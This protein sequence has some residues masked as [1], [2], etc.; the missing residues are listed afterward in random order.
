MKHSFV[1]KSFSK[2][3]GAVSPIEWDKSGKPKK[4]TI[5]TEWGE[6]YI[7]INKNQDSMLKPYLNRV[8][9]AYGHVHKND[10]G[11]KF[12]SLK[13]LNLLGFPGSTP[14]ENQPHI[15]DL[16]EEYALHIPHD[17]FS[18]AV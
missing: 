13:K 4:F 7:I 16:Y 11:D 14:A 6:D 3:V 17:E 2:V 15:N 5:F 9:E 18:R 12:L 10:D 8:V 1:P